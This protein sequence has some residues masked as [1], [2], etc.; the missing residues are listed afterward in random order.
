[1]DH[2]DKKENVEDREEMENV[3]S[4]DLQDPKESL[5]FKV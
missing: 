4:L 3:V 5:G 2:Q 1:L